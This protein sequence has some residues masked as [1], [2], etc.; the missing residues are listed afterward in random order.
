MIE[1]KQVK[2]GQGKFRIGRIEKLHAEAAAKAVAKELQQEQN[3]KADMTAYERAKEAA[4]NAALIDLIRKNILL[5]LPNELVGLCNNY[6]PDIKLPADNPVLVACN[7]PSS[8]PGGMARTYWGAPAENA[9][10]NGVVRKQD[11]TQIAIF[12]LSDLS[13]Y[14][15]Y[16]IYDGI[17]QSFDW[18]DTAVAGK[19]AWHVIDV[20]SAVNVLSDDVS[21]DIVL[22][23]PDKWEERQVLQTDKESEDSAMVFSD[24]KITA[25]K[26]GEE[27]GFVFE[28]PEDEEDGL[29]QM[30]PLGI[31]TIPES[32]VLALCAKDTQSAEWKEI[33]DWP[34]NTKIKLMTNIKSVEFDTSG[35]T[36]TLRI[37]YGQVEIDFNEK[38]IGEEEEVYT[39][40]AVVS[41][42][43]C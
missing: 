33:S 4:Q 27:T 20:V 1:N 3:R 36:L 7:K 39:D 11:G 43:E 38:T 42:T 25:D 17:T 37:K 13:N 10:W 26:E 24:L 14:R 16:L 12:D 8:S 5:I 9:K 18:Q 28:K 32:G 21:G 31:G 22:P 41:G 15:Q 19:L 40:P 29:S 6:P 35:N 34:E 23:V 30:K 2:S